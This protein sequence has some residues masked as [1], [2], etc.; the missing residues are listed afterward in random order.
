M[1][2]SLTKSA[3]AKQNCYSENCLK[4]LNFG[5]TIFLCCEMDLPLLSNSNWT[6][7]YLLHWY[8]DELLG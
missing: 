6:K 5:F 7:V 8:L 2:I 1:K 4:A 3:F